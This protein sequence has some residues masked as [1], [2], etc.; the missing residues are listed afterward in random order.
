[1]PRFVVTTNV[2]EDYFV[3]ADD[4]ADARA[5]VAD[6]ETRALLPSKPGGDNG[7]MQIIAVTE[8]GA[9]A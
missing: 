7:D 1:M 4:E 2:Y 9:L 5:Y 8:L 6:S 3:E